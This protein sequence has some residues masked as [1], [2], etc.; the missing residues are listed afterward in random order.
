MTGLNQ[1][2]PRTVTSTDDHDATRRPPS[3]RIA[4]DL[5][6][7]I[8]NGELAP[9]EQLPSERQL[10]ATYGTARNTA[11]EAFRLLATA[12]LVI[13]HHGKGVFVRSTGPL[14][15]LDHTR[16]TTPSQN[17]DLTPFAA[18]CARQD[19]TSRVETLSVERVNPPPHVAERLDLPPR[20]KSVVRRESISYADDEPMQRAT[21][22]IPWS[23]AKGTS[24]TQ[25]DPEHRHGIHG[26]LEG[27]G[28]HMARTCDEV[29]A[30]M[31]TP[32]EITALNVPPGVPVLD[33]LHTS[34]DQDGHAYEL[35]RSVIRADL[36]E[37][38]YSATVE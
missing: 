30:R 13:A 22:W 32:K 19:K 31:P 36:T 37:L 16:Y 2:Y 9:G 4:D 29:D 33:V 27:Q 8:D 17:D 15:Q 5:R 3:Q 1:S 10:A 6:A 38:I 25:P 12:G 35:T 34:T 18:A 20:Q 23:I 14:I 24:L 11:R 28:H 7:A 26:V 21:T